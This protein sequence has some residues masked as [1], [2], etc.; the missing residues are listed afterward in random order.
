MAITRTI[1]QLAADLRI[2]D[3]TEAPTGAAGVVLARIDA[4]ARALI[5]AYAP[6]APDAIQNE[7][8]S[9]LCGWLYDTDPSGRSGS[10]DALKASGA[11]SLLAPYRSKRAGRISAGTG[12]VAA[13][14]GGVDQIARDAAAANAQAIAA[15]R[16]ARETADT[17]IEG[18]A[19]ANTK[20]ASGWAL[21]DLAAAIV[22]R[23]LPTGGTANQVLAK[24]ADN[25]SIAWRAVSTLIADGSITVAK[26]S[27]QL[28]ARLLPTGGSDGQVLGRS[29][30]SPAW[31]AG[32]SGPTDAV[33]RAAAAANTQRL[34]ALAEE[35]TDLTGPSPSTGW[36]QAQATQA[37]IGLSNRVNA[38]SAIAH[39]A[40]LTWF[41]GAAAGLGANQFRWPVIRAAAGDDPRQVRYF[42]TQAADGSGA[43][44]TQLV[45]DW[46]KFGSDDDWDYYV[47]SASTIEGPAGA[48]TGYVRV[49]VTGEAAHLGSS[50]FAGILTGGLKNGIVKVIALAA[51][52]TA[53]LLPT[54]GG[55]GKFLGYTG[56]SPAWVDAPAGGGSAN[57]KAVAIGNIEPAGNRSEPSAA[58]GSVSITPSSNT[59]K[60]LLEVT[61]RVDTAD[62]NTGTQIDATI[63][64]GTDASGTLRLEGGVPPAIAKTMCFRTIVSPASTSEQTWSV[65]FKTNGGSASQIFIHNIVFSATELS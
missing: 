23:L 11:A 3:G 65:R 56:G 41:Q 16:S 46:H 6:L 15:E 12:G 47:H 49:E 8:Y 14:S 21:S 4:T 24:A 37:Q 31:V 55:N 27:A 2:G 13:P 51:E 18:K 53:R 42:A 5:L 26:L 64:D 32:P 60:I 54:G 28:V 19:D 36:T 59:A 45:D 33:A 30:G 25:A 39:V 17:R 20:P 35:L 44:F 1:E 10:P 40:D 22:A 43:A 57:I 50:K 63:R 58:D 38:P 34:A 52:V 48:G 29:G 9:R 61:A 62:T 7:A